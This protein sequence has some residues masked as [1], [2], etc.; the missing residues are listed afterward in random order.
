M[1]ENSFISECEIITKKK[2]ALDAVFSLFFRID[3]VSELTCKARIYDI[4]SV[5]LEQ[6][7]YIEFSS[8]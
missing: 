1:W 5:V 2:I 4:I 6:H 7:F 3:R 8:F